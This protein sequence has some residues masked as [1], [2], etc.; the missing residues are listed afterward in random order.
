MK[1]T[2]FASL[3]AL[4][5]PASAT[6]TIGDLQG[7]WTVNYFLKNPQQVGQC[8]LVVD[9]NLNTSGNCQNITY[10]LDSTIVYGSGTISKNC[11]VK[12]TMYMD[13]GQ[14]VTFSVKAAANLQTMNGSIRARLNSHSWSGTAT[15]TKTG[16]LSC[17]VVPQ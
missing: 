7:Q 11:A 12:G 16:G 8:T 9:N 14:K 17:Q 13:D 6:C 1:K 10:G 3:L 15:L 4:S 5:A 2:I